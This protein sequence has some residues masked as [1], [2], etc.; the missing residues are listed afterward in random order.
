MEFTCYW[1]LVH[2]CSTISLQMLQSIC[3]GKKIRTNC[4][5]S[6]I[7]LY[8]S[9]IPQ[10]MQ[11]E[12]ILQAAIKLNET[13][14]NISYYQYYQTDKN[15]TSVALKQLGGIF[16][17][18]YNKLSQIENISN[19]PAPILRDSSLRVTKNKAA[20]VQRVAKNKI[21]VVQNMK[22]ISRKSIE[23]ILSYKG[24]TA[25]VRRVRCRN[26]RRF[27]QQMTKAVPT[28]L[29]IIPDHK[30][31]TAIPITLQPSILP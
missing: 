8:K 19:K 3:T 16:L 15:N 23:P 5:N 13:L 10:N 22:A 20:T 6:Q 12:E 9:N 7:F 28:K 2:R 11:Q 1:Y 29:Y 31:Y 4:S 21:T 14:E 24:E 17:K 26:E 18:A 25:R 30:E 27:E